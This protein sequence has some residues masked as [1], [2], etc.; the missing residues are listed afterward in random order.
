MD[1]LIIICK[2]GAIVREPL[3]GALISDKQPSVV[4]NN[5]YWRRRL[6]GGDVLLY[7]EKE[8]EAEVKETV[9]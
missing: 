8:K 7:K 9:K 6:S 5:S 3:T 1:P 2:E 4:E